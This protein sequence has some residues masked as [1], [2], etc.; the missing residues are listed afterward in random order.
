MR[1]L[2]LQ[3]HERFAELDPMATFAIQKQADINETPAQHHVAMTPRHAP[4]QIFPIEVGSRILQ[5]LAAP[6]MKQ[7]ESAAAK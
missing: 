4:R 7:M 5:T 2:L 1:E 3:R 6:K